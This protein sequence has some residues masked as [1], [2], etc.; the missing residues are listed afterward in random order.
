[1]T[2]LQLGSLLQIVKRLVKD[3]YVGVKISVWSMTDDC[4]VWICQHWC[5]QKC[6]VTLSD[7]RAQG[8]KPNT[9]AETEGQD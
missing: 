3:S 1:M 9:M 8:T 5:F 2:I 4:V 6:I 7:F